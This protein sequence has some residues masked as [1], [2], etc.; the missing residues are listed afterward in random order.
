MQT[1]QLASP[2]KQSIFQRDEHFTIGIEE[3][4]IKKKIQWTS[5][6]VVTLPPYKS[7]TVATWEIL[8]WARGICLC[9]G[10]HETY[11]EW[12][13]QGEMKALIKKCVCCW[14][15]FGIQILRFRF[16]YL[17]FATFDVTGACNNS[18]FINHWVICAFSS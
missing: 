7:F 6:S 8:A 1:L 12:W 5:I 17:F 13:W 10:R 9:Q 15:F 16:F 3:Q 11:T 14:N 2:K 4:G 18:V